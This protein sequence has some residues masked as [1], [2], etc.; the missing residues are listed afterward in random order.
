MKELPYVT[1]GL[2]PITAKTLENV[3]ALPSKYKPRKEKLLTAADILRYLYMDGELED[4]SRRATDPTKHTIE[5][6]IHPT[7]SNPALYKLGLC[8]NIVEK[9]HQRVRLS[10]RNY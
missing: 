3:H 1:T 5:S 10:A 7:S 2:A 9:K 8:I 4:G 6:V